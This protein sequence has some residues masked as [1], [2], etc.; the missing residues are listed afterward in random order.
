M[1]K[2]KNLFIALIVFILVGCGVNADESLYEES[3]EA[4]LDYFAVEEY[5]DSETQFN[6]ALEVK[7]NDEQA[8]TFL[9]QT[10]A[11]QEAL[12]LFEEGKFDEGVIKAQT[13]IDTE[14]GAASIS[15]KAEE[16]ITEQK[17]MQE[18]LAQETEEAA[19]KAAAEKAAAEKEAA[20]KAERERIEAEEAAAQAKADEEAE[21]RTTYEF[22]DF[23]GYYL[24]S[25]MF[26]GIAQDEVI[27][28]WLGGGANT[29]EILETSI[30]SNMLSMNYF[31]P[32]PYAEGGGFYG[33]ME[34][35]LNEASGEK[36]ISFSFEPDLEFNEASYEEVVSNGYSIVDFVN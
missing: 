11:Y 24:R 7:E 20:E 27:V 17:E 18:R 19:E 21:K 31:I 35:T 1:L 10:A 4:G 22:S 2:G 30:N 5:D 3:I 26:A 28:A 14:N 25:D 23:I 6:Q 29:Y 13:V 16:L 32:D 12:Q 33:S 34:I 15:N 9:A 36:S 8:E